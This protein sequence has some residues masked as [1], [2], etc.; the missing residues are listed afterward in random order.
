MWVA[1]QKLSNYFSIKFKKKKDINIF[2]TNI[3][4]TKILL[5]KC[6]RGYRFDINVV[7]I[8]RVFLHGDGK[9]IRRKPDRTAQGSFTTCSLA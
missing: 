1:L 4:I 8:N 7:M 3:T 6:F 5:E 2:N 9:V